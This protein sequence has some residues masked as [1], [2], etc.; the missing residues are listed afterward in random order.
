MVSRVQ[1]I[2]LDV[3]VANIPFPEMVNYMKV[4]R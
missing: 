2:F 4:R 1:T 3:V